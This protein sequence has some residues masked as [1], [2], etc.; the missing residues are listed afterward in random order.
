WFQ[1]RYQEELGLRWGIALKGQSNIIGTVGFNNYTKNHR[2]NLG[3]DLQRDYWNHGYITEVLNTV[4]NFGFN[5]L[6]INRIE[7]EV[8]AGNIA[9]ERVLLKI[10]FKKEGVL[11]EWMYWNQ[12]HFDMT[13]FSL[14]KNDYELKLAN[15]EKE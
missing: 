10:G 5:N 7:A 15:P 14:L 9:S 13:M 11:R 12:K 8:M 6:L 1:A 4:I 3:Y 2:A